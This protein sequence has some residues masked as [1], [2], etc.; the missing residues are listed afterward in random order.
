MF[1]KDGFDLRFERF[2]RQS[3]SLFGLLSLFLVIPRRSWNAKC[4][5][6]NRQGSQPPGQRLLRQTDALL[7]GKSI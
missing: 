2:V 6:E 5:E 3:P 4:L 1:L 7:K